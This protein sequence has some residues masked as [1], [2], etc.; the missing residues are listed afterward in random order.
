[1]GIIY[2]LIASFEMVYARVTSTPAP[3]LPSTFGNQ[4]AGDSI[5][6]RF[7]S[8]PSASNGL[9]LRCLSAPPPSQ[10]VLDFNDAGG[11]CYIY[12][13]PPMSNLPT[14]EA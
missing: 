3:S 10:G 4:R 6:A 2:I 14:V 13:S 8:L 9:F 11:A 12:I 5:F 7:T 1:M